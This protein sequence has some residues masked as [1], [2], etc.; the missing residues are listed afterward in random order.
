MNVLLVER[1]INKSLPM[2]FLPC[3]FTYL[4]TSVKKV[5]NKK[6][7]NLDKKGKVVKREEKLDKEDGV[8]K[9]VGTED[10]EE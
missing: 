9:R 5:M 7:E 6:E 10:K 4:Y 8:A 2:H 1:V 3:L